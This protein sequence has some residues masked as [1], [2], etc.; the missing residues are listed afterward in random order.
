MIK[1]FLRDIPDLGLNLNQTVKANEIGLSDDSFKCLTPLQIKARIEKAIDAILV[2]AQ[3]EAE[4]EVPCARCL[5][6]IRAERC[7]QYDL[8]F[9]ITPETEF[10]DLSEDLRQELVITLTEISL[11]QPDC[12]GICPGCGINLNKNECDCSQKESSGTGL[13]GRSGTSV[14]TE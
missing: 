7:D 13:F 2:K 1:I 14:N 3:V 5:E 11:C 12:R 8:Y 4:Y 6:P 10:I 9:E